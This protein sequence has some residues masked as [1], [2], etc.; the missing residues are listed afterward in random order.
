MPELF[1][2]K[3]LMPDNLK[4]KFESTWSKNF[5]EDVFCRIDETI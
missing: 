2:E 4:K 1:S 3:N 5:Y